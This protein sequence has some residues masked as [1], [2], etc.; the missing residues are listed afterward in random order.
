MPHVNFSGKREAAPGIG[1]ICQC[2][3][4]QATETFHD[5]VEYF[6]DGTGTQG[7]LTEHVFL[8]WLGL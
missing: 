2:S 7:T 3:R 8:A 5:R 6:R 4:R 1:C